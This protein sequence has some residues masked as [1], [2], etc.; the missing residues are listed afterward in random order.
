[1]NN[2][3][4]LK[5]ILIVAFPIL[6]FTQSSCK[7]F[8]E[9]DA[10]P[11]LIQS[12]QLFANDATALSAVNGVYLQMRA[13]SPSFANGTL[14]VYG[15]LCA[16]ELTPLTPV[17][18]Y[19]AFSK[20]SVLSTS[21]I[22]SSQMWGS[23]YRVLYRTNAIVENLQRSTG[24][25][26]ATKKQ[27][28]GEMKVV[29]ALSY[30]IL[31]NLFGDVPLIVSSDYRENEHKPRA[32]VNEVYQQIINDLTDAVNLLSED[33]PS[34]GRLRPNKL[35]AAALL[36]KAYLFNSDWSNAEIL[37]SLVIVS[38]RYNLPANLNDVFKVTSAETIWQIA[39]ANESR[40][41]VEGSLFIPSSIT[42][43]PTFSLSSSLK[44]AFESG[45]LRKTNW[46]GVN[47]V[48]GNQYYYPFKYKRRTATPVDE[49][50]I[51]LRLSEQ[52]LIRSEARA[53]QNRI[54]EAIADLNMVRSRAGLPNTL[55]SDQATLLSAII[56]ERRVE[57]FAEWGNR[58]LDLKRYGLTNT[59]LAP[60]K[61]NNWQ[62]TDILMPV[63]F[64]EIQINTSLIQNPGY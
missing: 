1:M 48:N 30:F 49:Y 52:Y 2:K 39:P 11:N 35:T 6:F 62:E 18:E 7:K 20:N 55:A 31:V 40:N 8:V 17:L 26:T 43:I 25:S 13:V 61:G 4:Y 5:L 21:T 56:S 16:D 36:A 60:L 28:I 53:R 63:P 41:T 29:R 24:V 44:I 3:I 19:D 54:A 27:L 23:A 37:S 33:Y 47:T 50:N 38:G 10:S 46:L 42:S 14:S 34:N 59:I 64:A 32:A 22:V 12:D 58:W 51:V 57:L 15:G 9:I 45:D